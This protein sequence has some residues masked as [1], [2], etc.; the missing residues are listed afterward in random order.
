MTLILVLQVA[1]MFLI[2]IWFSL[3]AYIA[4]YVG[5]YTSLSE[6]LI[7]GDEE[8][9]WLGWLVTLPVVLF[10][11]TAVVVGY[12]LRYGRLRKL[13]FYKKGRR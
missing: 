11:N 4:T 13:L 1:G 9:N 5:R 12:Y 10:L 2:L 7:A 8:L 3:V 6:E